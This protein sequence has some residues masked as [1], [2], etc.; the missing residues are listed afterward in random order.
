M[1][2]STLKERTNREKSGYSRRG[3]G[4]KRARRK[5]RRKANEG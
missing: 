5:A 1:L 2:R 3:G 4:N